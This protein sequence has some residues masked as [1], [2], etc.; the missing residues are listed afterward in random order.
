MSSDP[1]TDIQERHEVASSEHQLTRTGVFLG[2]LGGLLLVC[3]MGLTVCDVIGRYVFNAPIVGATELT[4]LL[5]CAVIFLGLGAVSLAEDHVTVDLLTDKFP[6][7]VQPLRQGIIGLFSGGI[8][9]IVAWRI[10]VYADQIGGYGGQTTNLHIPIAPL[11][12]FCATCA[13]VGAVITAA[14]PLKRLLSS[15]KA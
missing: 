8:L 11:G 6:D 5:L 7:A 12:Y 10:W 1:K 13:L 3:M 14:L 15:K 9:I 2:G 4:E